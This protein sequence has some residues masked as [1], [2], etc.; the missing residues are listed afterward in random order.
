MEEGWPRCV[1]L[2]GVFDAGFVEVACMLTHRG[3]GA[4]ACMNVGSAGNAAQCTVTV[5][6]PVL[7]RDRATVSPLT[8]ATM[9]DARFLEQLALMFDGG[10][11]AADMCD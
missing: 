8:P 1:C 4:T 6:R 3:R 10:W 9:D 7:C 2:A 5:H 11:R